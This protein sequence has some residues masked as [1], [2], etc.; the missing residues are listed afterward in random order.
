MAEF[1]MTDLG[2]LHYFLGIEVVQS[3]TGI[4]IM[5]KKYAVE[6]LDR[7]EMKTCNSV[8]TPIEPGLKLT[9]DPKGKK[10]DITLFKQ[11]VGSLMYLTATRTY[12]MYAVSL[13]SRYMEHPTEHHLSAAK[14][15]L[16][17]LKGTI[18]FGIF[19]KKGEMSEL[20]GFTDSDYAGDLD[21]R[22]STSGYVF[23]LSDGAVSWSSKKQQIVTL[24]STE[25]EFV[26]AAGCACQA[27]CYLAA[28]VDYQDGIVDM[29]FC[30]SE[31]QLADIFTKPLKP[32]VYVKLREL[33]GVC[34][35]KDVDFDGKEL[36]CWSF[37]CYKL[38]S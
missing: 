11:I 8:G 26:A 24:S 5:Q 37:L 31:V 1:E 18:D 23:M 4:F 12:I 32:V 27:I 33:L 6:I 10:V 28:K 17:Y 38:M 7:F 15:V 20:V 13:I 29:T 2:L 3:A 14:R 35:R 19:Y 22:R 9:K 30:S 36:S 16:R 25:A 34:S 21:D